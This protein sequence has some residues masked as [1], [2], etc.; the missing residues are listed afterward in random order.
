MEW[1]LASA[2]S[3]FFMF[4]PVTNNRLLINTYVLTVCW[5]PW[6]FLR[7]TLDGRSFTTMS[8][9]GRMWWPPTA[10]VTTRNVT[11]GSGMSS[12]LQVRCLSSKRHGV[13]IVS[14][15]SICLLPFSDAAIVDQ[16]KWF[17]DHADQDQFCEEVEILEADFKRTI[18]S[19][20]RMSE[21]WSQLATNMTG[22]GSAAYA[23]WKAA[24]YKHL[25]EDCRQA[26]SNACAMASC[27]L[28]D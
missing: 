28:S 10:W 25:E 11:L 15:H 12:N 16:V 13:K 24:M 27:R 23:H 2:P 26:Y 22:P 3:H 7:L 5:L 19:F 1:P 14:H 20:G 8:S 4:W 18:I 6:A 17:C 9:G 21:V